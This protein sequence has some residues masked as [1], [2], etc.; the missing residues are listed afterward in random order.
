[1]DPLLCVCV[2]CIIFFLLF[3]LNTKKKKIDG[4]RYARVLNIFISSIIP[5]LS[6]QRKSITACVGCGKFQNVF[7]Q[8]QQRYHSHLA[9]LTT[10][11]KY[12]N[13][14]VNARPAEPSIAIY[15]L[16]LLGR[17][18]E[19]LAIYLK[20]LEEEGFP[21]REALYQLT[22]ALYKSN[23]LVGMYAV[24]DTLI[25]YY[26]QNPPS[27]RSARAMIYM[28]TMLINLIVNNTRPVDMRTI[29]HLCK[30]IN[31]FYTGTN[32]VMYNTLIKTLLRQGRLES[33]QAMLQEVY[34]N[35]KPTVVTYGILIKDASRR[36][37][38]PRLMA[39]LDEMNQNDVPADYAIVS[40]L[41][42]TLCDLRGFDKAIDMVETLHR[43]SDLVPPKFRVQL[44]SSIQHKSNRVN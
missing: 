34:K 42:T 18:N 37:D 22:R 39:Y 7:H 40:I 11:K 4:M 1:M 10:V 23:N 44:L 5:T 12:S 33:A 24:H 21:S 9:E 13:T 17:S 20:L 16:S 14:H 6:V 25:S 29:T 43:I 36:K 38:I 3:F 2:V 8:Q 41:V 15:K 27:K 35:T 31:Q 19:A 30:E 28:Y 32:I 26:R